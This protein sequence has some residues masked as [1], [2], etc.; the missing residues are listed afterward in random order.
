LAKSIPRRMAAACF[1][2]HNELIVLGVFELKR[3]EKKRQPVQLSTEGRLFWIIIINKK[4]R[5]CW[6]FID[7]SWCFPQQHNNRLTLSC[8][9]HC[10]VHVG[11]RNKSP[12]LQ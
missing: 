11:F 3:R 4:V 7:G 9:F 5:V 8:S 12:M 2:P 6:S 10:L 1:E